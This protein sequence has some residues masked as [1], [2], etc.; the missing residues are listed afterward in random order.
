ME[1]ASSQSSYD[2]RRTDWQQ[3]QDQLQ[4]Q[5]ALRPPQQVMY[6][7]LTPSSPSM[8]AESPL[9]VL[10]SVVGS[11]FYVAP[12]V[13]QARGY[14]GPR[15]DVW[16]LGVILYAM[17][18]GN[19]PFGQELG[20]CK[21]FRH[22]CKWVRDQVAKTARFWE[23]PA[24]E[25]PPWLFPAKF[26]AQ[27]RGLIVSMLHPDPSCRITVLEAMAHPLC[28]Q[29]SP[30]EKTTSSLQAAAPETD[31]I[32]M[33]ISEN[34]YVASEQTAAAAAAKLSPVQQKTHEVVVDMDT[35]SKTS[36][37]RAAGNDDDDNENGDGGVFLM[38]EDGVS[39]N[40]DENAKRL[41]DLAGQ[42]QQQQ[43]LLHG[44][45]G[46]PK[47][48]LQA[49][50]ASSYG[51][52]YSLGSPL[53]NSSSQGHLLP[54]PP[55]APTFLQST[56]NVHDLIIGN[57]EA[58]VDSPSARSHVSAAAA[59]AAA[60]A[61]AMPIVPPS[62]SDSVKRSTRF[63]T[64]VPA[65]EVLEKVERVLEECKFQKVLT[66]IGVIG[67]IELQW[68]SFRLEVW[69]ADVNGPPLCALQLY[70]MSADVAST[71]TSPSHLLEMHN[72]GGG[73]LPRQLFLVEFV[74]G[75]L[76]IFAHKRFYQWVR[77]QISELVKRD[78]AY[79]FLDSSQ[80][81][82]VDSFLLQRYQSSGLG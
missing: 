52:G 60:A 49:S 73:M 48:Q 3:K 19:L 43:L 33:S 15:A 65:A 29:D 12:E 54:M 63:I 11:P 45:S 39:D 66:P 8:L 59:A 7:S 35:A 51:T 30:I 28:A 34:E 5:S 2:D 10:K 20:T 26:S 32:K 31:E 18:A 44:H 23:D 68:Q 17:L 38:E 42:Q 56:S 4:A 25:Y 81:P 6:T 13:L 76:E 37:T 71:P 9:R 79:K 27:A 40:E 14:D 61:E 1:N 77:T 53:S 78:Y 75:Q 69:G 74:R 80:S 72:D 36:T 47:N 16:S 57:D 62:F 21:R 22:F 24:L 64:A 58:E 82:M 55:V 46:S 70:Q 67:K 50:K 41:G